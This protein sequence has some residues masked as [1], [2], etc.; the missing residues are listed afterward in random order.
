M[1]KLDMALLEENI[2]KAAL[3][4]FENGKVFGSAYCVIR[5]SEVVYKKCF[6]SVSADTDEPVTEN[7][8]FRMASMT[9]PVTA[10]AVLILIER[11]LLSLSDKVSDFLPEFKDIHITHITQSGE[12]TDM[13]KAQNEITVCNLLTHTSG[14]GSDPLKDAGLSEEDIQSI[15]DTVNFYFRMGLDFEP[16]T[17]QQYSGFGAFDVLVKIIEKVSGTDYLE[18][19]TQEI[20]EPCGM[21]N[22]TFVPSPEQWKATIAMHNR[23]DGKSCNEKM[24]EDRVFSFFPCKHYLGGAGLVSTLADYAEFAKMLLNK[25]KTPA[26]RIVREDTFGLMH[27]PF[28]TEDIMPGSERWGLGVRVIVREDYENLPVGAF[29]WS[30][31]YGTHFWIDPV[32]NIAAVYM[33]NSV[34]DGGAANESARNFEKAVK[35]SLVDS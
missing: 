7:T 6:G 4:D 8:V 29:G 32:N 22:T 1:S 20:F 12:L 10:A 3:Y 14:I 2:E 9:K 5:G 30:G 18:F 11:G 24:I 19:L 23:V 28:V 33:K 34:V 16:G 27:T 13:G 21:K 17:K 35:D 26:K 25:G 15:D 31:A